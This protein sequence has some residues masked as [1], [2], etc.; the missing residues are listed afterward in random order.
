M[1]V[2]VTGA[3]SFL[4]QHIVGQ[5][6]DRGDTVTTFQR[7]SFDGP[8]ISIRGSIKD[9]D[10]INKAV[11]NQQAVIH[12]AAKVAPVGSWKD[13]YSINVEGTSAV[14]AAAAAE[15]ISK[16]IY[17]STPSVAHCGS[18]ISGQSAL[19]AMPDKVIGH[20]ARSKAI[21]EH[22][23]L[24]QSNRSLPVVAL[25]PHLVIGPGDPQLIG[26]VVNR[27]LHNRL[28]TVGSGLA[29][30]D[31]TWVDNAA[32]ATIAALDRCEFLAGK[33]LVVSN[34][35][36]RTIFELFSQITAAANIQW[37]QRSI[38]PKIATLAG[39]LIEKVWLL[40]HK[41]SEPPITSFMAKQLSTA[42][43]FD[44]SDTTS[45]L[46]WQPKISLDEGFELLHKWFAQN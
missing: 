23:L 22:W 39:H 17:I 18:S 9:S 31:T 29:L 4:G 21:A 20:Y 34:G 27:A 16:F 24:Q 26:R 35:E 36:P 25:R 42:H 3:T 38:S 10:A 5:L 30:V 11:A 6:V 41:K 32:S 45:A 28:F 33:A 1:K 2:L 14:H 44:Q 7:S 12:L 40:S 13:F 43:W 46:H 19:P 37:N 8:G 15:G